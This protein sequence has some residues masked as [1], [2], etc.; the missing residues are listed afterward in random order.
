MGRLLE[1]GLPPGPGGG[2]GGLEG[3]SPGPQVFAQALYDALLPGDVQVANV[4]AFGPLPKFGPADVPCDVVASGLQP[5]ARVGPYQLIRVLGAGGMAEV[6]LARR[7]DGVFKR[8]A[9]LKL[10][11]LSCLR[12]DL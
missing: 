8:E 9:A 10:P 11:L 2:P 5:G 12:A 6:W 7:A 3:L 4:Q 1:G